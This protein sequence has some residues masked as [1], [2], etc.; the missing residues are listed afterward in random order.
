MYCCTGC[1][2]CCCCCCTGWMLLII[3]GSFGSST[4]WIRKLKSF[5]VIE[6]LRALEFVRSPYLDA[7]RLNYTTQKIVRGL[8]Y[9]GLCKCRVSNGDRRI[10]V[11]YGFQQ[12]RWCRCWFLRWNIL[13]I[14]LNQFNIFF[15]KPKMVF[16]L[17]NGKKK[18]KPFHHFAASMNSNNFPALFGHSHKFR[19]I[20]RWFRLA[21]SN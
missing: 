7:N 18:Y 4:F 20:W 10:C 15:G 2:V 12:R 13:D 16:Y 6:T 3:C 8:L 21:S 1:C 19:G 14:N 5:I 9:W 17:N 11:G